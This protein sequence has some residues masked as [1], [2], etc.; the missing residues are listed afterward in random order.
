M[1]IIAAP[2]SL[3]EEDLKFQGSLG[4]MEKPS[5]GKKKKSLK[6]NKQTKNPIA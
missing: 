1:S 6:Q 3:R 4:Y 2:G 5:Q